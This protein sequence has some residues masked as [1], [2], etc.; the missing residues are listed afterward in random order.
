MQ[1]TTRTSDILK[2][3]L[4]QVQNTEVALIGSPEGRG[5]YSLNEEKECIKGVIHTEE[6][7]S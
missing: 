6:T 5:D 1:P 2:C 4:L 3:I 7:E